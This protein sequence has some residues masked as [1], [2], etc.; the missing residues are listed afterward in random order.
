MKKLIVLVALFICGFITTNLPRS[1]WCNELS[2]FGPKTY[3]RESQKPQVVS[4]TFSVADPSGTFTLVVKNGRNGQD[5]VSSAILRINGKQILGPSDF[6]QRVDRIVKPVSLEDSDQITVVLNSGPGS[7]LTV[8]VDTN[9]L[10]VTSL[11][12]DATGSSA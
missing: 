8:S 1:V 9:R 3:I 4:H 10:L 2:I 12:G 5:R 7:Y 11:T 6:N